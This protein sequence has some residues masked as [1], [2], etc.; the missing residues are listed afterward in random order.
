MVGAAVG[1]TLIIA[2][3]ASDVRLVDA[4]TFGVSAAL[5]NR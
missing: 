5:M 3:G 2:I 4:G 1:G